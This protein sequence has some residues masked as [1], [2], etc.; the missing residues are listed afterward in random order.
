MKNFEK[1]LCA[2]VERIILAAQ[3]N[4]FE[5]NQT[6]ITLDAEHSLRLKEPKSSDKQ[7]RE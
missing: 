1:E 3:S 6:L 5:G 2:E 7:L 4:G